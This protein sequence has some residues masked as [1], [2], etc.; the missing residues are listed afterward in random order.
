MEFLWDLTGAAF[1]KAETIATRSAFRGFFLDP[2]GSPGRPTQKQ[3][4]FPRSNRWRTGT[5]WTKADKIQKC[6]DG[7]RHKAEARQ[8]RKR[9]IQESN[10]RFLVPAVRKRRNLVRGLPEP[11]SG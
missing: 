6:F 8:Y 10:Y 2:V 11:K 1:S 4:H 7:C 5:A 3:C 9:A